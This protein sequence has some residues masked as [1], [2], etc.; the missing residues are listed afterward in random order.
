MSPIEAVIEQTRSEVLGF[1][2]RRAGHL[3]SPEDVLQRA[4][5]RAWTHQ[6]QLRDPRRARAWLFRIVRNVL[7]EELR[8]LTPAIEAAQ[9]DVTAEAAEVCRCALALAKS[10]KPEYSAILERVIVDETPV[11]ALAPE[12]GLTPNAATVRLHRAR[13]ALRVL[14]NAHC[15]TDSLRDSF[16]CV[17]DER[18][19]LTADAG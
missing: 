6:T 7:V 19:C 11:S 9:D 17:C 18:A 10:L 15:E 12:L 8:R 1:V 13:V 4:A 16:S 2:R 3:V 5:L 14:V